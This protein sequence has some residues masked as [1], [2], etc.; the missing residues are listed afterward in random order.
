MIEDAYAFAS[1]FTVPK[2]HEELPEE[3]SK[4]TEDLALPVKLQAERNPV[5]DFEIDFPA[6]DKYFSLLTKS[7]PNEDEMIKALE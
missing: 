5:S 1:S 4:S 7:L 6:L 3:N 2:H